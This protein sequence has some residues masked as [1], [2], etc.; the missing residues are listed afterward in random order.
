MDVRHLLD[1]RLHERTENL[2]H[3]RL[4][5]DMATLEGVRGMHT[6]WF[7]RERVKADVTGGRRVEV[8]HCKGERET[9]AVPVYMC[10]TKNKLERTLRTKKGIEIVAKS[11]W[12][13]E[14]MLLM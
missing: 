13:N 10:A 8:K 5:K 11:W 14:S 7:A 12:M 9:R 2:K 1:V 3:V 6:A 4:A